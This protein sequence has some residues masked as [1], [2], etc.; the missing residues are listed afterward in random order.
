MLSNEDL[1]SHL[2]SLM[3]LLYLGKTRK[4]K[5]RA[6]QMMCLPEFRQLLLDFFNIAAM[7]L[8]FMMQYDSINLVL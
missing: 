1:F 5:N 3:S 2:A 6:L 8:I 7:Q 4:R